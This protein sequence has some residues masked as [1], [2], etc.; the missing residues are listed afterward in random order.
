MYF[1]SSCAKISGPPAM[2]ARASLALDCKVTALVSAFDKA[3]LRSML[4]K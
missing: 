4:P 3:D 2:Y 1:G